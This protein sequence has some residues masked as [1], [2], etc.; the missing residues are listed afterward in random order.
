MGAWTSFFETAA[1]ASATL[2]G[3]L[4]VAISINLTRILDFPQLPSRA[5][6]ALVPLAGVMVVSM[7]ALVPQPARVFGV[8]VLVAG[9]AIWALAGFLLIK[10]LR[11]TEG[12]Q[13]SWVI[14]HVPVNQAQTLPLVVAGVLLTLGFPSGLYWIVAGMIASML[15][16]LMNAWVLMVEILR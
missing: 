8:E 15:A 1:G 16:A 10:S 3:L 2:V 13:R 4:V 5:G 12:L 6:S 9:L 14:S 11:L 7:L